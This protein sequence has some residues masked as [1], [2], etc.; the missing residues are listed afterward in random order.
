M[1][2]PESVVDAVALQVK[3]NPSKAGLIIWKATQKYSG[4]DTYS[5]NFEV[6]KHELA[7]LVGAR[8]IYGRKKNNKQLKLL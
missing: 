7:K 1:S 3:A 2:I 8:S 5:D 6:Y 4:Y